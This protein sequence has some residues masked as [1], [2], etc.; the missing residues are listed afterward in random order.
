M[1]T[2]TFNYFNAAKFLR[3]CWNSGFQPILQSSDIPHD[4]YTFIIPDGAESLALD[5]CFNF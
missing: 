5:Y 2:R 1:I 4:E 3:E